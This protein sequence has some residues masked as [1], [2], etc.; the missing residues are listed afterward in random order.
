MAPSL[1]LTDAYLLDSSYLFIYLSVY[2]LM[3]LKDVK[4]K[5]PLAPRIGLGGKKGRKGGGRYILQHFHMN[6]QGMFGEE[7][8]PFFI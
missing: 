3:G 7:S 4:A 5:F 6:E 8:S 1:M 2:L